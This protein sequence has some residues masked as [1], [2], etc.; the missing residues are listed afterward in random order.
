M[1]FNFQ[2][3]G[4]VLKD[5][6]S[7]VLKKHCVSSLIVMFKPH[8]RNPSGTCHTVPLFLIRGKILSLREYLRR[9]PCFFSV[10]LFGSNPLPPVSLHRKVRQTTE[11]KRCCDRG[12]ERW[13]P[14]KT[15]AKESVG[16]L[17]P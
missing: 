10:V 13:E 5:F 15:T 12:E 7:N 2:F 3:Y 16:F 9:G 4:N 8:L 1:Q 14:K 17:F 6:F 11:V